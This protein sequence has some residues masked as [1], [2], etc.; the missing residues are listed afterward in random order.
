MA[1]EQ[2]PETTETEQTKSGQVVFN[3]QEDFDAVISR[4]LAK[5]K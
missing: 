4:R 5:E 2:K 1:E 3:S